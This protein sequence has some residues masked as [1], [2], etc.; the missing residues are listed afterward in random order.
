MKIVF[1]EPYYDLNQL[2]GAVFL[3]FNNEKIY[4][5]LH[6]STSLY[7]T[8]V[9]PLYFAKFVNSKSPKWLNK[10]NFAFNLWQANIE[11]CHLVSKTITPLKDI[12]Y[13]TIFLSYPRNSSAFEESKKLI[14]S[15]SLHID[16]ISKLINPSLAVDELFSHILF[17]KYLEIYHSEKSSIELVEMGEKAI[18]VGIKS[19]DIDFDF[20]ALYE[21]CN[22][23]FS[24]EPLKSILN[25]T[26][27]F[28][29][30]L[31]KAY[32]DILLSNENLI[33][34]LNS[35][36]IQDNFNN[37]NSNDEDKLNVI[38]WELFRQIL[39][40]EFDQL[41]EKKIN[42]ILKIRKKRNGEID[43]LKD[44]CL[45]IA[46]DF[47]N[48]KNF[49]TLKNKISLHVKTKVRK[50]IKELLE[51]SENVLNE[52]LIS[53]FSDEKTWLAIS[54]FIVS[55]FSESSIITAGSAMAGLSFLGANA[56][57]I[58]AEK[59]KKI[60]QSDYVLIYRIKKYLK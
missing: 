34:F 53:I 29:L 35:L 5:T 14:D 32:N 46:N 21:Y 2:S 19:I 13:K 50:E 43:K 18:D 1:P 56:F 33:K 6:P 11:K 16:E 31:F 20:T 36:P 8:G 48:E 39:S 57:K 40:T 60:K 58:A 9:N 7:M 49:D 42:I 10:F 23:F 3:F 26:Y 30:P 17:E 24:S 47:Y 37:I 22:T 55:L 45:S 27:M 28:R 51:I 54:A 4:F 59:N 15:S 44:K 12:A 38:A 41:D 52:Y 25:K